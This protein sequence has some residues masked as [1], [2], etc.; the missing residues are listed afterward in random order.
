M[1]SLRANLQSCKTLTYGKPLIIYWRS[2][3]TQFM[4]ALYLFFLIIIKVSTPFVS[5]FTTII[6]IHKTN[7]NLPK[8]LLLAI[9]LSLQLLYQHIIVLTRMPFGELS[10]QIKEIHS[11]RIIL[12]MAYIIIL[13]NHSIKECKMWM[14]KEETKQKGIKNYIHLTLWN[15]RSN[16]RNRHKQ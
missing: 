1:F 14:I 11:S 7:T 13:N 3:Q 10:I 16:G 15:R 9:K 6:K 5:M 4:H 8:I 2:I 12:K